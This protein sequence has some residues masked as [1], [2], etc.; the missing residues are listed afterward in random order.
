MVWPTWFD[1]A[2]TG[3]ATGAWA[4]LAWSLPRSTRWRATDDQGGSYLGTTTG[5]SS[6]FGLHTNELTFVP[7]LDPAATAL[8]IIAPSAIDATA[9]SATIQLPT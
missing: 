5:G 1:I 4:E 2:L 3:P 6:S 9:A 7:S 8:T